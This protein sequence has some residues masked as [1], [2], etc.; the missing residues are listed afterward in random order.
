MTRRA[1]DDTLAKLRAMLAIDQA[2]RRDDTFVPSKHRP[3]PTARTRKPSSRA[4][5]LEIEVKARRDPFNR[6]EHVRVPYLGEPPKTPAAA[7]K[8]R[9]DAM[10][11]CPCRMCA[12]ALYPP[13]TFEE[14]ERLG[15]R[16]PSFARVAEEWEMFTGASRPFTEEQFNRAVEMGVES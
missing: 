15:L 6:A 16:A 7:A 10:Q 1:D 2:G 4:T 12:L 5:S 3:T 13:T 9:R 8:L 14:Y 11:M